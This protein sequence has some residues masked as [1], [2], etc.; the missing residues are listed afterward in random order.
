MS[1]VLHPATASKLPIEKKSPDDR[2]K[3]FSS[4]LHKTDLKPKPK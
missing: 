2:R 4:V 3:T 1:A